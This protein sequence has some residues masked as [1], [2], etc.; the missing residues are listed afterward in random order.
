MNQTPTK[1]IDKIIQNKID[2]I[3]NIIVSKVDNILS[4]INSETQIIETQTI[5]VLDLDPINKFLD[6]K[7]LDGKPLMLDPTGER[8]IG[9]VLDDGSFEPFKLS[10][11]NL[12]L[13]MKMS[14]I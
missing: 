4:D 3:S 5:E 11:K 8:Y 9:V 1:A 7:L 2:S 12:L 10:L 13:S 14:T 6:K